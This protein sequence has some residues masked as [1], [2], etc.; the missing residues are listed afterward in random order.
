VQAHL[1]L[2]YF[3]AGGGH[4]AAATALQTAIAQ[5]GRPWTVRL[6][7]LFEVLD[8]ERHCQRWLRMAPED[9]YNR[10]L[11]RGATRGMRL[12]LRAL[13]AA[14]RLANRP[15]VARLAA[16]W[17]ATRPPAGVPQAVVSLIP[18]FNRCLY[19]S[20]Q[21]ALPAVPYVTVLTDMADYPP[22][23][24][25]EPHQ[26]QHLVCGTPHAVQQAL[27]QGHA[28]GRVHHVR[29]MLLRPDFHEA[30]TPLDEGA[31]R[32]ARAALGL[33]PD[34]PTAVMMFGGHGAMQMLDLARA[35]PQLQL[36]LMCGHNEALVQAARALHRP[37]PHAVV[38][39]TPEVARHMRLADFFIG[40]PGPGCLSEAVQCGL[41]VLTFANAATIPQEKFN[42]DWVRGHDLGVVVDSLHAV[43][44]GVSRLLP[45]LDALRA[46]VRAVDNRAVYEV[47]EILAGL[48][49]AAARQAGAPSPAGQLPLASSAPATA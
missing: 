33:D 15:L 8:P 4:R 20:V 35:L 14:I 19:Q 39:F 28:A 21:R 16:H 40:K 6:V 42:A 10:R 34:L 9:L 26:D 30:A 23:F 36:I 46:N 5:Q 2:V 45:R 27:A 7:N 47:P 48:L 37:R 38:G 24:W 44:Q 17:Q 18:N 3:N 25:I 32:A 43:P 29:G 1:D 41:P 49:E 11:A 22:H 31:R 13:Q 12:E